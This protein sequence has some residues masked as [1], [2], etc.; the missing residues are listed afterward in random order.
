MSKMSKSK[1]NGI[2]PQAM[3][4]Q[5]GADTIRLYTVFASPPEQTLEWSESGR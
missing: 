5:Y 4:D 1:N 2:D 3:I